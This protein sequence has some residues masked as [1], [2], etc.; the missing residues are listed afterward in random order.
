MANGIANAIECQV[1]EVPSDVPVVSTSGEKSIASPS[2][3]MSS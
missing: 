2:V 1:G 3:T